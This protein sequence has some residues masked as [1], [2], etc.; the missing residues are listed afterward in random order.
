MINE[1]VGQGFRLTHV[2]GYAIYGQ[3][4][5]AASYPQTLAPRRGYCL[6]QRRQGDV[7]EGR[8]GPVGLPSRGTRT[9][10]GL[11]VWLSGVGSSSLPRDGA[12]VAVA[13]D[14]KLGKVGSGLEL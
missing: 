5:Y 3:V 10:A 7:E 13:A 8:M 6:R 4:Q 2:S 11:A 1:L 9:L 14:E 12:C